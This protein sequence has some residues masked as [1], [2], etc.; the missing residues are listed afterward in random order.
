[1]SLGELAAALASAQGEI[2]GAP[3]TSLNPHF[4]SRYSDLSEVWSACR[5]AL[6]KHKIAVIQSPQFDLEGAWLETHLIHASGQSMIGRFPLRPTKPD[7]QGFGSAISYAKRYSLASMIGVVSEED[8][9]GNEA[10][11]K[12]VAAT[13]QFRSVPPPIVARAV[14]P[15]EVKV[16]SDAPA[17][18]KGFDSKN[19]EHVDKLFAEL[20]RLNIKGQWQTNVISAMAG[21]SFTDLENI[22]KTSNP[23]TPDKEPT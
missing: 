8:D 7:M 16:K 9:D 5:A 18:S 4:K 11:S 15:P 17:A 3:K 10:S 23:E 13:N 6:S 2:Q 21:K 14:V 20:K 19:K 12:N 1:M 22:I